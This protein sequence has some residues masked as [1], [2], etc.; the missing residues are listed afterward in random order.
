MS[1]V[2][3][4]SPKDMFEQ[5]RFFAQIPTL[6]EKIITREI[7]TRASIELDLIVEAEELQQAVDNW[8]LMNQLDS[9]EATQMWLQ[10]H[11]LTLNE[12]GELI[13]ATV[14]SS[15]LAQHLFGDKIE[16]YFVDYQ[17]DYMQ[18]AMYEIVLNDQDVA[19]ELSYAIAEGEIS[20]FE[21]AY[22][23]I[24]DP[25]L[26]RRGGYRGIIYRKDLKPEISAAVF[27]SNPPQTLKPIVTSSGVHLI[28]VEEL[29][30]PQ[31]DDMMRQK[32]LS[33]LF[34]TWL[35]KQIQQFEVKM[36]FMTNREQVLEPQSVR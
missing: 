34:D 1:E 3:T 19:M 11:H 14:L 23:Y 33:E 24:Q 12:F 20:F 18:V 29:A 28:K 36:N 21:A 26:S 32:I 8:R 13:S 16:P 22:Q 4:F 6:N 27:A 7:V 30:K 17:L 10:K 9:V 25:Q 31:L 2:L 35:V 15:K 5:L